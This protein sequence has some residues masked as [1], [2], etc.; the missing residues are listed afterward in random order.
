MA[1]VVVIVGSLAMLMAAGC[2]GGSTE[3]PSSTTA[4][5]TVASSGAGAAGGQ[6]TAVAKEI[7]AAFDEI[8]AKA[9]DLAKAK[10]EPAVL[11][12]QLE[13]L[14]SSYTAKM[15]ELNGKYLG[16]RDSDIAQFGECNTYLGEN[17]GKHVAAKDNTLTPALQYYN[18]QLG[19]QEI[20]SLLSQKP[21]DLLDVAVKQ[22]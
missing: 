20:V 6:G 1:T 9:A 15:T 13:E 8:V 14:Y 17:R 16:L 4:A 21:V 3:A 18:L 22:N 7:L 11:K 19:D 5:T 12:P 2:G 10:P